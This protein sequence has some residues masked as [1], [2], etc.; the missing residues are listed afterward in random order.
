MIRLAPM[1]DSP[2]LDVVIE[3]LG[4]CEVPLDREDHLGDR[5]GKGLALL[6]RP[7][8]HE[9]RLTLR[10]PRN[11]EGTADFE[12]AA[13][14]IQQVQLLGIEKNPRRLVY[15]KRILLPAIPEPAH[16]VD[17]FTG[18]RITVRNVGMPVITEVMRFER[19]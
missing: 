13:D 6:G 14:V 12:V 15:E 2:S 5:G 7:G 4:R 18:D 17:E 10:G 3:G 9:D 19:G 8:L 1:R 11:R 16:H